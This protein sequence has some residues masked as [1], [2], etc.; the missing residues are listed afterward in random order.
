MFIL[1][2]SALV[3]LASAVAAL[4]FGNA[5]AEKVSKDS[6]N[7][8]KAE[9]TSNDTE[10]VDISKLSE[11]FGHFIGRNLN[12]PGLKLDLESI[13]KGMR[14][15][16]AGKPAPM[17]D[18]EYEAMMAKVQERAYHQLAEDNLKAANEF[19]TKNAKAD[20]VKEIVPSKL[21]YLILQEGTGPEVVEHSSPMIKYTGKYIDGTVFGSSE[22]VGGPI[23]I[24]LDQTIPGFSKGILGMKEGEKRR[25]FVHP[26]LA[27]GKSGQLPPNSLL[28]FDIEV[29]KANDTS[30]GQESA[31]DQLEELLPLAADDADL[32]S[33]DLESDSDDNDEIHSH[34]QTKMMK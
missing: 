32:D 4:T 12:N 16:A 14:E 29:V 30:K 22:D 25:L 31:N 18:Q 21:Q 10:Q 33:D 34:H 8:K 27:Y 11:A 28:I 9:T 2:R 6:E 5:F 1:K 19:L 7:E 20:H 13:I 15:G 17:S 3:A 23:T 26:E 24:P